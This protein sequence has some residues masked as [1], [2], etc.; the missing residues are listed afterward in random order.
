MSIVR[1][2]AHPPRL[3]GAVALA[4]RCSPRAPGAQGL[5]E[6]TNYV[7]LKNP[8]AG[9]DR[10]EHRG[11]RVLLVRLPALRRARAA[12][13]RPGSRPSRPTCTFR[14]IPVMFQPRWEDLAK[15]YYTLEALGEEAK[16]SPEVF[17]AIHARKARS[18][19]TRRTSSTGRRA[20]GSTARRSR[21]STARSRSSARSIARSSSRRRTASSR[22]R[23]SSSTASTRP[24]RRSCRAGHAAVPGA[25]DCAGAEGARRTT[26]VVSEARR[27]C[28][29]SSPARRRASVRRWRGTTRRAGATLGLFARRE[30]ELA[31]LAAALAP[32][33]RR[34]L[35]AATCASR[36]CSRAPAPDFIARFGAP[37]VVIANAGVSRGTLTDAPEDLPAFRAIF[38]TNV[39][40]IVHTFA[41]FVA[42]D[43]R[44]AR[45]HARRRRQ[46]RGLS[47]P[48][49]IGRVL[50][51]RRR[52]RSPISKSCAWSFADRASRW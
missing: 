18:C 44:R 23:R 16:L 37:D 36:R 34:D 6:G 39:L 4:L 17:A 42:R 38:D 15:V 41:P 28:A 7:R 14:R 30:A 8:H 31:R 26:E 40:G 5:A 22:C 2:V 51:R 10:Q 20:R 27:R 48:A 3:L 43:A 35:R 45:G 24:V 29:S 13:C 46:R 19:G 12:C 49:G 9:R 1:S 11:D 21:S 33:D 50:R 32:A 47:R 25:I 52:P